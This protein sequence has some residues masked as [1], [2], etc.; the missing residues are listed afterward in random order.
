LLKHKGLPTVRPLLPFFLVVSGTTLLMTSVVQPFTLP[1][2]G[3]YGAV[4][5]VEALRVARKH[6]L[7]LAPIVASIFPVIHVSHGVGF[8]A[9]LVKYL[10]EPDWDS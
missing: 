9:G 5:T 7:H 2:F 4:N 10:R 8:A 1:A 6:G 3:L